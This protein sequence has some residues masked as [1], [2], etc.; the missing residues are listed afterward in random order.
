MRRADTPSIGSIAWSAKECHHAVFVACV[1]PTPGEQCERAYASI[2]LLQALA[3]ARLPPIP[4]VR[5]TRLIP[6]VTAAG[7]ELCGSRSE[8]QAGAIAPED[9][10]VSVPIADEE[11]RTKVDEVCPHQRTVPQKLTR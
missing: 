8:T 5:V 11:I 3:R 1:D 6:S 10:W 4:R 9:G 7:N 2:D